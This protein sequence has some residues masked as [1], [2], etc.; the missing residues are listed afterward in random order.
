MLTLTAA[1][2]DSRQQ[3]GIGRG[4]ACNDLTRPLQ[5]FYGVKLRRFD[6]R[7]ASPAVQEN[8]AAGPGSVCVAL[9]T[10]PGAGCAHLTLIVQRGSS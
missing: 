1:M 4:V 5:A 7:R 10:T 9:S 3:R 6:C 8:A 2:L